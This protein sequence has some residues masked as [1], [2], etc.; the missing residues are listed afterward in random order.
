MPRTRAA[1]SSV[2]SVSLT[3]LPDADDTQPNISVLQ[4]PPRDEMRSFVSAESR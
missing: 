4:D 1:K 3:A 2:R